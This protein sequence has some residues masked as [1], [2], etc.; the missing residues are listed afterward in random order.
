MTP[1]NDIVRLLTPPRMRSGDLM[2]ALLDSLLHRTIGEAQ[3]AERYRDNTVAQYSNIGQREVLERLLNQRYPDHNIWIEGTETGHILLFERPD[4]TP[5]HT[6][7]QI[8]GGNYTTP[9]ANAGRGLTVRHTG[10]AQRIYH[11]VL[12]TQTHGGQ[13]LVISAQH[14][15]FNGTDFIIHQTGMSSVEIEAMRHY[16]QRI[17]FLGVGFD[18]VTP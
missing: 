15:A 9:V 10:N 12:R 11:P 13:P 2:M 6:Y 16:V 18:I 8:A 5:N 3:D 4:Y 1:W 17:V 14:L 7:R